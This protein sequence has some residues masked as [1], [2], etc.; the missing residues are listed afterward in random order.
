MI[1]SRLNEKVN[2]S[3]CYHYG[4]MSQLAEDEGVDGKTTRLPGPQLQLEIFAPTLR[5]CVVWRRSDDWNCDLVVRGPLVVQ[6]KKGERQCRGYLTR[7]H[8]EGTVSAPA[9]YD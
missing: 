5:V 4:I 2:H 1:L 7:L 9:F 3:M 6:M 8:A